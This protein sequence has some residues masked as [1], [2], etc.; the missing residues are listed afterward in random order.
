MSADNSEELHRLDL[1]SISCSPLIVV[2]YDLHV[3]CPISMLEL[4]F[5]L[6]R[7]NNHTTRNLRLSN[8]ELIHAYETYST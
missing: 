7:L 3:M 6:D 4:S 5:A 8:Y 2:K 1:I